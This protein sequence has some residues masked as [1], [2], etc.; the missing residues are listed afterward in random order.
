MKQKLKLVAVTMSVLGLMGSA[1]V[2]AATQTTKHKHHKKSHCAT[3]KQDYKGMGALPVQPAPVVE[4]APKVDPYQVTMDSIT[5]NTGRAVHSSPDWYQ[6]IG[7]T[8]GSNFDA[9]WGNRSFG[10]QGENNRRLS[11]NDTYL[12][13]TALVND[14]TKAFA[15]LSFNNATGGNTSATEVLLSTKRGTYSYAYTNNR[16]DLEQ[17][18]ITIGNFDCSPFFVQL[19]KQFQEF[20]KYQIHP[21]E[22]TMTQVLSESLQTSAKVGFLTRMGIHG[23]V[24]AFDNSLVQNGNGHTK[25]IFGASLGI[26]QPSEQLGYDFGLGYMS[27]MTGVNDVANNI[28]NYET[29]VALNGTGGTNLPGTY[30]STVGA[31][32]AYGD[33]NSGPF[34]IGARY[35]SAI[36]TF[37][38]ATLSTVFNNATGGSGARPWATDITAGYGFNA[39]TKSQNVYAG[40]QASGN[41]VNMLLP[42]G[43]WLLGYGVDM[44]KNTSLG[45]EWGHDM[46]YSSS[47]GGTGN[48]SNTIGARAAVKFG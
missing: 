39:W 37:K 21:I 25:T 29:I 6:R 14:W 33:I 10:Y 20:G 30:N 3:A 45:L 12:N 31:W 46:D 27:S 35:T 32:N 8:G 1:D 44:W 17:G 36:Q 42:R 19:G 9:H 40:Y 4:M 47:K 26:D 34:W 7:I 5:Q 43:R 16:L 23:S 38:A 24:Y 48:S 41:A 18:Y 22:R 28:T 13:A 15:S 2:L 11:L